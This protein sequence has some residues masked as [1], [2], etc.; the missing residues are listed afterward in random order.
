MKVIE[1]LALTLLILV[2][3]CGELAVPP[4]GSY[5]EVLLVTE[6]GEGDRWASLAATLIAVEHDYIIDQEKA[7]HITYVRA[8]QMEEFPIVKNIVIC[9]VADA[10]TTVGQKIIALV[11]REGA[12]SVQAGQANIL[13]KENLPQRGQLT[14]VITARNAD[15][16]AAVIAQRGGEFAEILEAS[17]RERLR[18][19]LLSRRNHE[20]AEE[21]F[22]RYGIRI[23]VPW[24]YHLVRGERQPPGIELIREP[25]T[26]SLGIFWT[27]WTTPP[28]VNDADTLFD[29]RAKYVWK[30]YDEDQMERDRV[31][32]EQTRLGA[33]DAVKMSGYWF[34]D[35]SVVGGYFETY[36][37]YDDN[38]EL[39]WAIDLLVFAPG[40]P[41]HPLFRELK[42]I[43]E[44]FRVS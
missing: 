20:L 12:E 26:R 25:P 24:L 32:F 11:G 36:F 19:H 37:I 6:G 17:C 3:G 28:T 42:A 2:P 31:T 9:G 27:D 14:L 39:M 18:R 16:L 41:K 22:R 15:E 44:T 40:K 43:A 1:L 34:N 30:R 4:A 21:L 23:Q 5:S 35:K 13:K 33:N 38:A 10:G 8:D 7:F 29:V